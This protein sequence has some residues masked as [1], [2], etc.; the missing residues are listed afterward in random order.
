[1]GGIFG[2]AMD[3]NFKKNQEFMLKTQQLQLERQLAMQNEMRERQMAVMIAR[4]RD[5]FWFYTAFDSL[6]TV[7]LTLG[8][9]RSKK[10]GL[11]A[12]LVPLSFVFAYQWD[13]AYGSKMDRI[14]AMADRIIDEEHQLLDLPHGLPTFSSIEAARLEQKKNVSYKPG[15]DIF[16]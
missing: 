2:K 6:A 5:M 7:G 8:A 14:R 1:M 12:P 11:L 10:Y 9:M 4:A 13:L 3:E 16:L 15:H